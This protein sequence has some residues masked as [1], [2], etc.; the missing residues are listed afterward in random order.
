MQDIYNVLNIVQ[1]FEWLC[2]TVILNVGQLRNL[3]IL[4][5]KEQALL[6]KMPVKIPTYP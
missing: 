4:L 6:A 1:N 3:S 5:L 2:K